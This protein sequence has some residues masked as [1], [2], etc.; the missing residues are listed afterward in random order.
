MLGI[1]FIYHHIYWTGFLS[2]LW[3]MYPE[4]LK[5][6]QSGI[7]FI[8]SLLD[9]QKLFFIEGRRLH[10]CAC[11]LHSLSVFFFDRLFCVKLYMY[12][13]YKQNQNIILVPDILVMYAFVHIL[14]VCVHYF[15]CNL[16]F[17]LHIVVV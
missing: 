2:C 3:F 13:Y 7:I 8:S 12:R 16:C 9:L 4:S 1:A 11:L 14:F 10:Q 17:S 15:A 5:I 6:S